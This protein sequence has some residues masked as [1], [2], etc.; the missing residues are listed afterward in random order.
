VGNWSRC[1]AE[2]VLLPDLNATRKRKRFAIRAGCQAC[3]GKD[4]RPSSCPG[5]RC[6]CA[7]LQHATVQLVFAPTIFV[8]KRGRLHARVHA[9]RLPFGDLEDPMCN[10]RR[11]VH[12]AWSVLTSASR[13][14]TWLACRARGG[15]IVS[16]HI[17][18]LPCGPRLSPLYYRC[19]LAAYPLIFFVVAAQT[20]L[21][22]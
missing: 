2:R 9:W 17:S 5:C 8:I 1:G 13:V 18:R 14:Q 15:G 12:A 6:S 3:C 20:A 11:D 10:P 19:H 7:P 16:V 4:D 22:H 21:A